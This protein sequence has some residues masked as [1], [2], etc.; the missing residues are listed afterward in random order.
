MLDERSGWVGE[1]YGLDHSHNPK[2]PSSH[3][4]PEEEH[5]LVEG[6]TLIDESNPSHRCMAAIALLNGPSIPLP[7]LQEAL[8]TSPHLATLNE[9]EGG[10]KEHTSC[11]VYMLRFTRFIPLTSLT[12][13]GSLDTFRELTTHLYG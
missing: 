1:K 7:S 4:E 3:V 8:I 12:C 13:Y 2:Y 11:L 9:K 10:S 6:E 5:R